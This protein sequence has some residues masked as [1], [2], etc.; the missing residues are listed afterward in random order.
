MTFDWQTLKT[1]GDELSETHDESHLRSAISRYYYAPY[2]STKYYLINIGHLEY[3][4]SKGSH[5]TLYKEL[6]KSPDYNEQLLGGLLEKLFK[7]RVDVDYLTERNG[8]IID[9]DYF[10]KELYDV[11][12]NSKEALKL[13]SILK[14]NPPKHRF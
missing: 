7:K 12:N 3:L 6:K 2:C 8:K 10:K 1:V 13:V 5:R 14:N 11:K 4:G 9:G